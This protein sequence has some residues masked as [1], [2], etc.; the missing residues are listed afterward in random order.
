LVVTHILA[1]LMSREGGGRKA[2]S[3]GDRHSAVSVV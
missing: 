2:M 3:G 1:V